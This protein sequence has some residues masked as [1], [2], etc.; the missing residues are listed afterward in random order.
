MRRLPLASAVAAALVAS[1]A[2]VGCAATPSGSGSDAAPPP[3]SA[4][5]GADLGTLPEALP[6]GE[7]LGQGT[8]LD[9]GDGPELCLGG[10]AESHP[11]Q[12]S[13][14]A[15]DGWDWSS[16]DG[17]QEA[18][19]VRW[20][21]YAVQGTFDGE[22]VVVTS[23]PIM[24]ALFDPMPAETQDLG[25]G[26]TDESVLVDIQEALMDALGDRL[27]GSAPQDGRLEQVVLYDDGSLQAHL[28]GVYGADV[29]HV[30]SA[31]RDVPAS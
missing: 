28:D 20:G 12:C 6:L 13:G 14:P 26:T 22:R 18:S 30:V 21:A 7:V 2:L 17:W 5:P 23:P 24:L 29:V 8:V 3:A 11:P 10:V 1:V 19:G 4:D 27:L 25:P 16:I 9:R 15:L 31:L